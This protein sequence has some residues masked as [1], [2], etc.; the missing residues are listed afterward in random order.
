MSAAVL[1]ILTLFIDATAACTTF[2]VGR[3]ATADGSVLAS[4]SNDGDGVTAGN[5]KLIR[6]SDWKLPVR[7]HG[8]VP[9]VAHTHAYFT[10]AGGYASMNEFQVGLAEST[11]VAA[12]TANRSAGARLN[13][14]D[15]GALGLERASN[16]RAAVQVMGG[17]AERF[18]YA[19]NGESL[20]VYDPG[21]AFIFHVLPDDTGASAVWVAQRV[22]DDHVAVVANAFTVRQVAFDDPHAFLTSSNMRT[23]PGRPN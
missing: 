3:G 1:A 22:P 4:H 17:L 21:E 16:A 6:A 11:C 5:L 20:L 8:D 12:F 18:G 19:D 14:V 10:K 23:P 7:T 9:Q 13:I 2:V 15:L